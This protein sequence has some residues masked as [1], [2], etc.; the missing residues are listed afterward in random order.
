M[1]LPLFPIA[2]AVFVR[3]RKLTDMIQTCALRRIAPLATFLASAF[4]VLS[5]TVASAQASPSAPK[6]A[7]LSGTAVTCT[8]GTVKGDVGVWPGRTMPVVNPLAPGVYCFEPPVAALTGV[9][10]FL[11]AQHNPN[12]TWLFLVKGALTGTNLTVSLLNGARACN[13]GWW[14]KDAATLTNSAFAGSI[15]AG[16]A[17]TVTGGTLNGNAWATGAVTLTGATVSACQAVVPASGPAICVDEGHAGD[18]H[19]DEKGDG[20]DAQS[21]DDKDGRDKDRHDKDGDRGGRNDGP[22]HGTNSKR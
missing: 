18:R 11:D 2:H 5:T 15:L 12:A 20:S 21:G 19:D 9:T 6:F 10:V 13:V 17:I 7:V 3:G 8:D 22:D 14:V 1:R 16:A 4:T